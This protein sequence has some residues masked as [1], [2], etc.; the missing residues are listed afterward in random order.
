MDR[1]SA[2][3]AV[4]AGTE[5]CPCAAFAEWGC[6]WSRVE[7][8]APTANGIVVRSRNG[9]GARG[10]RQ[11][12]A[13]PRGQASEG[14]AAPL[15]RPRV[16]RFGARAHR[17]TSSRT[18]CVQWSSGA[19][20]PTGTEGTVAEEPAN[21]RCS[22][23]GGRMIK[24]S[25]M[26]LNTSDGALPQEPRTSIAIHVDGVRSSRRAVPRDDVEQGNSPRTVGGSPSCF[27]RRAGGLLFAVVLSFRRR[28]QHS[29]AILCRYPNDTNTEPMLQISQVKL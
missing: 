4:C 16:R 11:A 10:P 6:G 23:K 15:R 9:G 27:I 19:H 8:W 12:S 24:V 22:R 7:P 14:G 26:V 28:R 1:V 3:R 21:L 18:P 17:A 29:G 20:A 13:L 25:V 5:S 2:G